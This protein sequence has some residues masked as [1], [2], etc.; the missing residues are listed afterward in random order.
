MNARCS[1]HAVIF[2]IRTAYHGQTY[3]VQERS[4]GEKT[5]LSAY[6]WATKVAAGMPCRWEIRVGCARCRVTGVEPGFKR[7]A[8]TECAGERTRLVPCVTPQEWAALA[9]LPDPTVD[10]GEDWPRCSEELTLPA[11]RAA[12]MVEDGPTGPVPTEAAAWMLRNA[13]G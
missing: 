9:A 3:E 11:L 13:R 8:C 5:F 10:L 2:A 4:A 12:G 7:K 6:R 1:F